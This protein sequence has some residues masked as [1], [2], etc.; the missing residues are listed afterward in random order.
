MFLV[1]VC[2]CICV[3]RTNE[4]T[5]PDIECVYADTSM[6]SIVSIITD[7]TCSVSFAMVLRLYVCICC[8]INTVMTLIL[9]RYYAKFEPAILLLTP[10]PPPTLL[11]DDAGKHIISDI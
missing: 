5:T 11:P 8:I 6:Q 4:T 1:Y 10:P 3:L 9:P 7:V 2:R